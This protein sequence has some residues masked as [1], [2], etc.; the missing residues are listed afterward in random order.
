MAL[1]VLKID[2]PYTNQKAKCRSDGS[3]R[4]EEEFNKEGGQGGW[5]EGLQFDLGRPREEV[6]VRATVVSRA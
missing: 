1:V 2:S 5:A 4:Y 6:K 3:K